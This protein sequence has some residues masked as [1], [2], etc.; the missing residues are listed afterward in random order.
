VGNTGE[1]TRL[2]A[3][4]V[5]SVRS[6]LCIQDTSRKR[7]SASKT[8]GAWVGTVI[9]TN[10]DGVYVTVSQVEW[11]KSW[12]MVADTLKEHKQGVWLWC[13]TP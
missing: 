1:E 3:R 5:A 4:W 8:L 11:K 12:N 9:L 6:F 10:T 2:G 13:D 7:Q